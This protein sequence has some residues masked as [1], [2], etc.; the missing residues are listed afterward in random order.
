MPVITQGLGTVG[1]NEAG[2]SMY[3]V[4]EQSAQ[5]YS[6]IDTGPWD[7]HITT[8]TEEDY[9]WGMNRTRELDFS[10]GGWDHH[11]T[12]PSGVD[13]AWGSSRTCQLDANIPTPITEHMPEHDDLFG[14]SSHHVMNSDDDLY[15]TS[16]DGEDDHHVDNANE[17]TSARV[18]MS[19]AT[20]TENIP[21]APEQ[22]LCEI[23]QFFNEVYH[24][25]IPDS[26]GI[27]SASRTN[28]YNPKRPELGVKMVFNSKGELIASVKDFSVRVL[29]REYIV[30]ESSPTIWKVKC[31]NWSEGGNCGWGLR[32]SF[33]K[34]LGYFIITKYGGDHTCMSTQVGIDH[35]NL[36]VNMIANTLLGIVRCDPA[37][38]IKYVRESIK[39]KYGYDISYAKA[40][41]S[42]KRAVEL[43]Y[44]T[45]ESSV[46]LLPKYMGALSKYNPGTVVECNHL[47]PYDHPHKVLNFVFWAFRP[48]IDGFRHCRNVISVDGTHMY[49]KYKHKL[50][51][52]VTLDANN[53]V[54][55]LAFALVDEENYE[56]WHWFLGNVAQHV[57]RGCSGVCLISDR[58][59][60]I[61]SAVQDL[62]DFRPPLGV[63]RFCLRHVC[64]NFNSRFKNIHL[65]DLCWEA[66][67]QH[68][69]SKFNATMEAIK[70]NNAAAFTYLSNIPK[71]KWSLALDGGWRR[72]IM[73]TN[74]SECI[75]RV[76]KGARRLPITAIVEMSFQRCV[77]YF[78]QRR[79]RSDKMLEKNQPWTDYAYSK[80][81]MWSKN[82]IEHRVVRFDQRD[83]TA[84][85]ATGGRPGRQHHVQA[86][87]ISTR[88][89]TCGKFTIFG[90]PCSHVICAAKW[91]GLNPAQLVQPWFTLS[92]YVNTYDGRFYP[93]HDEQYWDEPTFQ[94]RHNGVRR[95]R[96]Q[97]GRDRTTRIRNE[98]DQ[99]STRARQRGR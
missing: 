98:M 58:H 93:I 51:I 78:I 95:Q 64:S 69:V 70:T 36:D 20:M 30:V 8:H 4:D 24:E 38:E 60:G 40:W 73:T 15:A 34:S 1:L 94:L 82:S 96:R 23:P 43:V 12:G 81:D 56:S 97:A 6:G 90:I 61:T 31:K 80:F 16:S 59:A 28:F 46:T 41:Q 13:V 7:H 79:A 87:N 39:E 22:H 53:Q 44:G 71:E 9:A 48:C 86:V 35:H 54:F 89:C 11:I 19:G 47:R 88:D 14:D 66:G 57:T 17:G 65:K 26:F 92:E 74:M 52:A 75:N 76:L 99:P 72:G 29:R 32:A 25:Q 67:I 62:P 18:L 55:P 83:K 3:H 2:P 45:W 50:L 77:Q 10:S 49:T 37:Y 91:F 33:K 27:P 84:S 5:A 42:L 63:H 21:I 85:V 68:Q